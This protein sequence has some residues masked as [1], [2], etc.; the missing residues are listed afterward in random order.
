M[1]RLAW[2][3]VGVHGAVTGPILFTRLSTSPPRVSAQIPEPDHDCGA[4]L[5]PVHVPLLYS[6]GDPW[7]LRGLVPS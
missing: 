7:V 3:Q 6:F 5:R 2:A 1:G 4:P